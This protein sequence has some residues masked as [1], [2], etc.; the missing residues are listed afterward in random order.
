MIAEDAIQWMSNE[1]RDYAQL[2]RTLDKLRRLKQRS[3]E[4]GNQ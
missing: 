3:N 2:Y 4:G 1:C